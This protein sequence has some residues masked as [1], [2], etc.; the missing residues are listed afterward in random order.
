MPSFRG[1]SEQPVH[2][3]WHGWTPGMSIAAL[4]PKIVQREPDPWIGSRIILLGNE[5]VD[6][7]EP[8]WMSCSCS[9]ST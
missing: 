4:S 2:G 9:A 6:D 1:E 7:S 5:P 3:R 8:S